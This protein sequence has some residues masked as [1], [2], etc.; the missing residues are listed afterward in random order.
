MMTTPSALRPRPSIAARATP[1]RFEAR[2]ASQ[3][4]R[5][6]TVH[7]T[8]A[9]GPTSAPAA[10]ADPRSS[11]S[12]SGSSDS[13]ATIPIDQQTS[14]TMMP[15]STRF[16]VSRRRPPVTTAGASRTEAHAR[17]GPT[18]PAAGRG[19]SRRST[20]VATRWTT[21]SRAKTATAASMAGRALTG[22]HQ[23]SAPE[24]SAPTASAA[25]RAVPERESSWSTSAPGDS[26]WT[27][28]T[29][30]ASSGPES[31]A[32]KAPMSAA[33]PTN[34]QKLCAKR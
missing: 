21:L 19:R 15:R 24:S 26:W 20:V 5:A 33:A 11:S 8:A 25:P 28:S 32:R 22:C 30:H 16:V 13:K 12:R 17:D 6:K 4:P 27:V 34:C 14:P 9:T 29:N 23:M 10:C 18:G 3:V 31:S 1:Q 7:P 2:P